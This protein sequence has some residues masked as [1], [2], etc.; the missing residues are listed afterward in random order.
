MTEGAP[1]EEVIFARDETANM[2]W[3]IEHVVQGPTGDPRERRLEPQPSQDFVTAPGTDLTYRLESQVPAWWIPMVPVANGTSG[4][5]HL[6]KGSFS[7]VD[8]AQGR[9]L[10]A[11]PL[12]L[13]EEEVPREGVVVRRVPS[14]ARDDQG[15]LRRWIARR[16]SVARGEASSSLAWDRALRK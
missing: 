12:D 5:F 9:I 15:K 6:R 13:F 2:V 4:G 8:A 10:A 1:I 14:L 7:A 11:V 3:A 16:V